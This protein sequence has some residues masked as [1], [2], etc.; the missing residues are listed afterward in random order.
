VVKWLFSLDAWVSDSFE[1]LEALKLACYSNHTNVVEW[2]LKMN[3]NIRLTEYVGDII[4]TLTKFTNVSILLMLYE[5]NPT[6]LQIYE[7]FHKAVLN[8]CEGGKL[9]NLIWLYELDNSIAKEFGQR[10]FYVAVSKNHINIID[11]FARTFPCKYYY[12]ANDEGTIT[13]ANCFNIGVLDRKEHTE[14]CEVLKKNWI[15][16]QEINET[17]LDEV[18]NSI[19]NEECTI[20]YEIKNAHILFQCGHSCCLR[21]AH[22]LDVVNETFKCHMCRHNMLP[23]FYSGIL[24]SK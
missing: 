8:A 9:E 6:S 7:K 18:Q 10:E 14:I 1:Y 21:C 24:L 15:I 11:W 3:D 22:N 5:R 2:L 19:L 4:I 17:T 20:C 16:S 23:E 12:E 13:L